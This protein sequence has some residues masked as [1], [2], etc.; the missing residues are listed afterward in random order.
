ERVGGAG[1]AGGAP[2]RGG[3]GE[4]EVGEQGRAALD[5]PHGHRAGVEGVSLA[6]SCSVHQSYLAIKVLGLLAVQ[7]TAASVSDPAG[8]RQVL[9]R[10]G[11][12]GQQL[13]RL[14]V[15]GTYRGS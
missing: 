4:R 9:G 1:G 10:L 11:E 13:R 5:R 12:T 15:D 6:G 8:A 3:D 2:P 7:V 14:W